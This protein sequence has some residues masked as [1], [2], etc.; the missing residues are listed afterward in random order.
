MDLFAGMAVVA[1]WIGWCVVNGLIAKS[2]NQDPAAMFLISLLFSPFLVYLYM[3]GLK[4][5]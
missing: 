5:R 1:W 3:V 2:R 4:Q